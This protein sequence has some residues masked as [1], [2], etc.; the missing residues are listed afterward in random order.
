MPIDLGGTSVTGITLVAYRNLVRHVGIPVPEPTLISKI[1]QLA[2][3]DERIQLRFDTDIRPIFLG[4]PDD[5]EDKITQRD[6]IG[7]FAK[8]N[9]E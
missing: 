4:A 7:R 6:E 3:T 8:E 2:D 1:M 5:W 9:N